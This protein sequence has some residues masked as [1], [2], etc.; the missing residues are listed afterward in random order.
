MNDRK[1]KPYM[2]SDW[3]AA[4]V[5]EG[6]KL[7]E[8][9]ESQNT[10]KCTIGRWARRFGIHMVQWSA[11]IRKYY[12]DQHYLDVID[13]EDKAYFLGLF[14]ADGCVM[15]QGWEAKIKLQNMDADV[16]EQLRTNVGYTGP[17]RRYAKDTCLA[18]C[19]I[20]LVAGLRKH[21]IL[22]RKSLTLPWPELP[23][24][25]VPAF[26]RG[27]FDGDGTI[28]RQVRLVSG[29]PMFVQGFC[30]WYEKHYGRRPYVCREDD[31]VNPK[32]R[33]ILNRRDAEFVHAMYRGATLGIKRKREY[34][35][36][37]WQD[38]GYAGLRPARGPYTQKS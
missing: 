1:D 8:I 16:L 4:R 13:T 19:S 9:A 10:A 29:S 30:D 2:H 36:K 26:M 27:M 6:K 21:G 35:G 3:L 31:G 15:K 14:A 24:T 25:M 38:Y 22:S 18:L 11:R 12:F 17:L 5:A 32:W 7:H 20:D 23:D 34:Y 28:G 33:V 37:F